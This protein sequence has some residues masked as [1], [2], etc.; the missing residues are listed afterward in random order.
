MAET[1]FFSWQADT[2]TTCGRN[3]IERALERALRSLASDAVI[4]EAVRDSL[5][6]DKD[7]KGVPGSPPIVDTIFG[8]IDEAAVFVPDLTFVGKRLDGRPTPNPNVLIE[9]GWALKRHGHSY[10]VPIMNIAHG[11]PNDRTLPFDL[12][13]LRH[14]ITYNCPD[15]ASDATRKTAREELAKKLA[16]AIKL[17]ITN[18]AFRTRKHPDAPFVPRQATDGRGRFRGTGE[19]IG[20]TDWAGEPAELYLCDWPLSWFRLMPLRTL[21]QEFTVTKLR[22]EVRP[23]GNLN[24]LHHFNVVYGD[25]LGVRGSD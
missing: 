25:P 18:P 2:S 24:R 15:D 12:K 3:L 9:Y 17:V 7:T 5:A 8:K 14:P 21:Q 4:E 19:S 22:G 20:F 16:D 10:M 1:I 6:V 23:S 11:E 13:H